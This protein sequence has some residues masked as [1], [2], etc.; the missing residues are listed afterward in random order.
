MNIALSISGLALVTWL[1]REAVI[2]KMIRKTGERPTHTF[3]QV[4]L[5]VF[6]VLIVLAITCVML[7]WV[8]E[9]FL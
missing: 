2:A 6:S 9:R 3:W 5:M 1:V 4:L 7:G 8:P